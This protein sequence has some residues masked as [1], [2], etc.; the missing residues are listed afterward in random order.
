MNSRQMMKNIPFSVPVSLTELVDYEEG[1]V[2]SRTSAQNSRVSLTLFAFD[3]GEGLSAH[4]SPGDALAHILDG[5]CLITIEGEEM[6][7]GPGEAVVMPANIP[8]AVQANKPFKML[9][10]VVKSP[11]EASRPG[12]CGRVPSHRSHR[13]RRCPRFR[14]RRR[15]LDH[16]SPRRRRVVVGAPARV[17]AGTV[18]LAISGASQMFTN[19]WSSTTP[20]P[21]PVC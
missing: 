17:L 11:G 10:A 4:S 1:R 9:L 3:A 12:A 8:H 2:V 18:L 14:A 20:R 6:I 13:L 5:E 7:V 21:E 15:R 16:L 19:T